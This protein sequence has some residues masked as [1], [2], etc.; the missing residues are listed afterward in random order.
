VEI[1]PKENMKKVKLPLRKKDGCTIESGN[2][3]VDPRMIGRLAPSILNRANNVDLKKVFLMR[4]SPGRL[5][6]IACASSAKRCSSHAALLRIEWLC[7]RTC[8]MILWFIHIYQISTSD[9]ARPG[10]MQKS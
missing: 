10:S 1:D 2:D 9:P 3:A 7:W 5:R 4:R 6:G 8:S